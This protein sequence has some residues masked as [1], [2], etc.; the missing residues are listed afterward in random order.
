MSSMLTSPTA[1]RRIAAIALTGVGLAAAAT[2]LDH[3]ASAQ[4]PATRTV[5]L[6]ELAKGSTFSHIRNTKGASRRSNQAGDVITFTNPV[7][8]DTGKRVGR[9]AAAC[10]TTTGNRDFSKSTITCQIVYTLRDGTV[11]VSANALIGA[12]TNTGAITGGT[13]AY[14]GARGSLTSAGGKT[15]DTDTFTL[16]G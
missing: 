1:H 9:L 16:L 10:V 11:T 3:T 5:V 14:Q 12:D 2:T 4:A 6:H 15:G 13:G 8:D 7:D